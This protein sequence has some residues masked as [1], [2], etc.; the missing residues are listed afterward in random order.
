MTNQFTADELPR[1]MQ[2]NGS[3]VMPASFPAID[4]DTS[5]RDEGAAAHFM[6]A[7]VFRNEF[8]IEEIVDRKA[9]N[10]Y[11]M[12]AEMAEYVAQYLMALDCGEVEVDTS[13]QLGNVRINARA[14][15]IKYR[16]ETATL[17]VDDLKYG[18]TPVEPEMHWT[19]I[20]HAFGYV[21]RTKQCAPEWY[22]FRIHQPR[23]Y[24]RDGKTR[25]WRVSARDMEALYKQLHDTLNNLRDELQTGPLCRKCPALATCP[26]ARAASMNAIDCT[27]LPYSDDMANDALSYELDLLNQAQSTLKSRLEAMQ[28]LALHRLKHGQIIDNYASE[29]GYGNRAWKEG[30]NADILSTMTGKELRK[31]GVVTPA[32]AERLGVPE[33][34]VQSLTYRPT[35]G[36]KLVRET[37]SKRA[38][39]LL[40]QGQP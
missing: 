6:A 14:D 29:T 35:T 38:Q 31:P 10:G 27:G 28:N 40:K 25:E 20:A 1:I 24:H 30:F 15:H 3:V 37:A 12:S 4:F 16:A 32:Q 21:F 17:T 5:A 7:A 2:C 36:V 23:P 9:P 39:R 18:F 34:V 19:L 13:F 33:A 11:Y 8:S 22:V 26:A